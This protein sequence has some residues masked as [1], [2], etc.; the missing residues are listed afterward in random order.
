MYYCIVRQRRKEEEGGGG[1]GVCPDGGWRRY[2]GRSPVSARRVISALHYPANNGDL[3]ELLARPQRLI[4]AQTDITLS[5]FILPETLGLELLCLLLAAD[6][7][8][9]Y[10]GAIYC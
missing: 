4:E 10:W 6:K 1:D 7:R 2:I 3:S 8:I 9:G 5:I